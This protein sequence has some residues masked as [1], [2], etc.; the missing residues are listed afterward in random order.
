MNVKEQIFTKEDFESSFLTNSQHQFKL[1]LSLLPT[2]TTKK[3]KLRFP[4]NPEFYVRVFFASQ[5]VQLQIFVL[6]LFLATK[7]AS[8]RFRNQD[9]GAGFFGLASIPSWCLSCTLVHSANRGEVN[10]WNLQFDQ[11]CN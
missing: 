7:G 5:G 1:Q 11:I 9:F 8:F 6:Q 2:L 10:P 4:V 3:A